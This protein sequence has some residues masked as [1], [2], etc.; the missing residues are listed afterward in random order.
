MRG[1]GLLDDSTDTTDEELVLRARTEPI[2]PAFKILYERHERDVF[3]FILRLVRDRTLAEDL[4]QETFLRAYR[5]LDRFDTN[6]S[7]RAWLYGIARYASL[8]ALRGRRDAAQL[9]DSVAARIHVVAEVESREQAARAR[10]ALDQLPP[11]TR[12]LLIQRHALGMKL[13]ELAES[14]DVA[15]RTIRNRLR[16]AGQELAVALWAVPTTGGVH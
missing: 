10:A 4:L 16:A 1:Q 2:Q 3:R 11:E 12:A 7:F 15:E 14:Y 5:H 9:S 6:R 13:A 8:N